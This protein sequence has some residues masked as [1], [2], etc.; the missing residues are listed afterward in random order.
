MRHKNVFT[1]MRKIDFFGNYLRLKCFNIW[2]KHIGLNHFNRV[3]KELVS[4]LFFAKP[5]FLTA[6]RRIHG[7]V[8][9]MSEM[10]MLSIT[11]NHLYNLEDFVHLQNETR[12]TILAPAMDK[13][14]SSV[15][16]VLEQTCLEAK[17]QAKIY[18]VW[19]PIMLCINFNGLNAASS[20]LMTSCHKL[21]SRSM[22]IL[23]SS[24]DW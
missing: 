5:A 6:L 3:R 10:E 23:W 9:E 14:S 15:Q 20:F 7:H 2:R 21:A 17:K 24:L 22:R 12:Q 16:E 19:S 1:L 4:K 13:V 18:R 11:S 8:Y